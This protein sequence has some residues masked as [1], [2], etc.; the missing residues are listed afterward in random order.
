MNCRKG[1]KDER[2]GN[3]HLQVVLE[4]W[5]QREYGTGCKHAA[6]LSSDTVGM[7]RRAET[8]IYIP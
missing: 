7:E 4:G 2:C 1:G 8:I 6:K 5:V 3:P